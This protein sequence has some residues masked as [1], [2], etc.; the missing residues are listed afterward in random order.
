MVSGV[1]VNE[2]MTIAA[3]LASLYLSDAVWSNGEED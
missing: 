1:D 2:Q 3:T